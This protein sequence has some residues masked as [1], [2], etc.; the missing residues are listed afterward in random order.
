MLGQRRRR[1]PNI[2]TTLDKSLVFLGKYGENG[3]R[4]GQQAQY[5][6]PMLGYC[7]ASVADSGPVLTQLWVIVCW[8]ASQTEIKLP[9]GNYSR[10]DAGL[11]PGSHRQTSQVTSTICVTATSRQRG[12]RARWGPGRVF[13]YKLRYIVGF[14]LVKMAISTNPKPTIYRNLNENTRRGPWE[15]LTC[16]YS[17]WCLNLPRKHHL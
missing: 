15:E 2:Y 11:K 8:L 3:R 10:V 14:R 13:A 6:D 1:W 5:V 17:Q 9:G 4:L 7:W 12:S 16:S